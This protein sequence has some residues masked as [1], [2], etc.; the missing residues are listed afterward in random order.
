MSMTSVIPAVRN[1]LQTLF[2][3][4][5]NDIT[6]PGVTVY[7]SDMNRV[8][9]NDY[10]VVGGAQRTLQP[11]EFVGGYGAGA[12]MEVITVTFEIHTTVYG[13]TPFPAADD[14]AYLI[15]DRCEQAIRNDPSLGGL[16]LQAHPSS[17]SSEHAIDESAA[18]VCDMLATIEISNPN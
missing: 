16:V 2:Q 7:L 11:F 15:L 13:A 4:A 10:I 1:H 8:D 3:Q 6:S 17:S 5:V 18:G 12:F 14:R 9:E